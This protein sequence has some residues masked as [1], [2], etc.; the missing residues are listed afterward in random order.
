MC[1]NHSYMF[2]Q[3]TNPAKIV[4]KTSKILQDLSRK[5]HVGHFMTWNLALAWHRF[6]ARRSRNFMHEECKTTKILGHF[7]GINVRLE[8]DSWTFWVQE[9]ARQF[10][11]GKASC[12][13]ESQD[14]FSPP[15]WLSAEQLAFPMHAVKV[16]FYLH[17]QANNDI[18]QWLSSYSYR[19]CSPIAF[20]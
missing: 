5:S 15:L 12:S 14:E 9:L 11:L 6:C 13:A 19:V 17:T 18:V 4:F 2:L 20:I 1:P 16:I 3:R 7:M 10:W 8:Q